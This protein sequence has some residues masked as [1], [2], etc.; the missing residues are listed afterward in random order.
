MRPLV[1]NRILHLLNLGLL[2]LLVGGGV[3]MYPRLP[4]Q[5]PAHFGASGAPD[6]WVETDVLSWF[7]IVFIGIGLVL[8][9]YGAAW[10]MT[11]RKGRVNMV[12]QAKYDALSP[13][14]KAEIMGVMQQVMYLLCSFMLLLFSALQWGT[15]QVAMG[16]AARLPGGVTVVLW[17]TVGVSFLLAPLLIWRLHM[18]IDA[19]HQAEQQ[20]S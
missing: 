18:K 15:Y 6:R 16:Y 8:L 14:G 5:M 10:W 11:Q 20:A 12:N 7:L 19:V 17:S 13:A 1:M 4:D 2:A 9:L 3:W